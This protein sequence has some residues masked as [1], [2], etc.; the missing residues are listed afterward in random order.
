MGTSIHSKNLGTATAV[1]ALS[2]LAADPIQ[3]QQSG[4]TNGLYWERDSG[5]IT[6]TR[7]DVFAYA[8][9]IPD[10]IN[11]LPVTS[12]GDWAFST[13]FNLTN[14][15]IPD[16]VRSL[17][18]EAFYGCD[19][20][21]NIKI[22]HSV[23]SIGHSAFNYCMK[24]NDITVEEGNPAYSSKG[25]VLFNKGGTEILK[26]P[27]DKE[28]SPTMFDGVRSIGDG[29][30]QDCHRLTN[31]IIPDSVTNMEDGAFHNCT[32]LTSIKISNGIASIERHTLTC[33]YSLAAITVEPGNVAYSS[34][35]GVLFNKDQTTIVKCPEARS[36]SFAIPES[37]TRIGENAFDGCRSLTNVTIPS[38]VTNIGDWAFGFCSELTD[39]KIP[40]G[41]PSI[42]ENTFNFCSK[43]ASITIPRSVT[44][45]EGEAFEYC[46]HLPSVTIPESVR[47]IGDTAFSGCENL[48]NVTFEGDT[49]KIGNDVF[50]GDPHLKTVHYVAGAKGWKSTFGGIPTAA[51]ESLG[52]GNTNSG[53]PTNRLFKAT[54]L[55]VPLK[56]LLYP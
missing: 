3:A 11:G 12:I 32:N 27:A 36:G 49:P 47:S 53:G 44:N 55:A 54:H 18:K 37:V 45:I 35:D 24:L 7:S 52:T 10:S 14:I 40:D 2:V 50:S 33:C 8:V 31:I 20:L 43:L 15:T 38:S 17:G 13:C 48:T 51:R 41:V 5:T 25:G 34:V 4:V 28:G 29:A 1:A 30:F 23:G 21:P 16:S 26:W 46:F 19:S 6:I 39:I 9:T 42:G 22:P 56:D